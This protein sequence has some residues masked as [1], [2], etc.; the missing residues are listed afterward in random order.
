MRAVVMQ[1]G[2]L[3][4]EQ[5]AEPA[6]GPG[7]VLVEVLA[8]GICGTDLHC[9]AHG[10]EFNEATRSAFGI[11][12][13]DLSRPVVFGHEFVGRVV[14]YGPGTEGRIPT[15]SRVVSMPALLRQPPAYLGFGGPEVPG[16]YAERI[17]L[18]EALLI[19][20]PDHVPTD[21]AALTEP[22]AVAYRTVA[23]AQSVWRSS[24]CSECMAR[25][26][27]WPRTCPRSAA[28]WPSVSAPTWSST[29]R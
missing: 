3:R 5:I 11:E 16:A 29:P 7:E 4:V 27:S 10:P 13:M 20:V 6:P 28:S 25:G 24:R 14:S 8:C 18:S 1:D 22:L 15:G 21:I 12:V 17:V 23:K 26:R 9:A 19:E 2:K